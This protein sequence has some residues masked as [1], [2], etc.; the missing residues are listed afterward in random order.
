MEVTEILQNE[1]SLIILRSGDLQKFADHLA[2]QILSGQP[3]PAIIKNEPEKPLT[4]A[5]AVKF[6]GKSRQTLIKWRK[7]GIIRS[8]R[9][10]GR[11]Y[12]KSSE[13][14][15]ALKKN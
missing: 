9:L 3:I 11:L 2:N 15:E 10:G 4:Q 8:Y 12:F 7:A 6:L 1:N 5:E 14:L 13:L